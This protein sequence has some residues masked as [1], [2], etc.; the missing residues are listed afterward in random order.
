[1]SHAP[2]TLR[3]SPDGLLH[4]RGLAKPSGFYL[5]RSIQ[6]SLAV[7]GLLGT[8]CVGA[9]FTLEAAVTKNALVPVAEDLGPHNWAQGPLSALGHALLPAHLAGLTVN[10]YLGLLAI[11]TVCYLVVLGF[12]SLLRPSLGLASVVGLH[13]L[14]VLGPLLLSWDVITYISY[15]HLGALYGFNPYLWGPGTVTTDPTFSFM[16]RPAWPD[17]YGPLY[18]L[19]TYAIAPLSLPQAQ[20]IL[21][22]LTAAASLGSVALVFQTAKRLGH[23]PLKPAL[24]VGLNPILL[25]WGVASAHNDVWVMPLVAGAIYLHVRGHY[26]LAPGALVAATAVKVSAGLLLPFAVLGSHRR[27]QAIV[28]TALAAV[29]V[30]IVVFAG[31]G[32]GLFNLL[33]SVPALENQS[34]GYNLPNF[35]TWLIHGT[36]WNATEPGPL[37]THAAKAIFIT[38][39]ALLLALTWRSHRWVSA[40]G[41][42]SILLL[43]A[44]TWPQPWYLAPLLPLAALSQS[45]RLRVA[46]V[47]MTGIMLVFSYPVT[48]LLF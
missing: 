42:A 41:W 24:F 3:P 28:G 43:L 45:R 46:T 6:L 12:S 27:K 39:T 9:V 10:R 1:V 44:T 34:S 36:P 11:W 48:K 30:G 26:R 13:V 25:V 2:K 7:L 21:K 38:I 35:V 19:G 4:R 18:T 31:F 14:F 29:A 40:A 8:F 32:G 47:A 17:P 16:T 33:N 20:W 37:I 23:N 22:A 15:A 5:P